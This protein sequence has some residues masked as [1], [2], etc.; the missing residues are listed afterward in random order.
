[1]LTPA[2]EY[3][4]DIELNT[5]LVAM[6][7]VTIL[8]MGIGNILMVLADLFNHATT[9]RRAGIHAGWMVLLLIVHFNLFWHTKAILEVEDWG[10]GDFLLAI[11]GPIL[12]F[13]ASS[14][15]LTSPSEVEQAD[16]KA[17]WLKI[18]RRF[19]L[20]FAAVQAWILVVDIAMVG[21]FSSGDVL[22]LALGVL[23]LFLAT[24]RSLKVHLV[25]LCVAWGIGMISAAMRTMGLVT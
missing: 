12:L 16:L 19:F 22:N 21:Q 13:F 7:F 18:A 8:C 24:S 3:L 23:A 9:S 15:L 6:M 17:F 14:V 10:F 4:M 11:A 5:L 1:M 2:K 20:M 25:G